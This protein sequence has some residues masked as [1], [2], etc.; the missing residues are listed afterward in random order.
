MPKLDH[1]LPVSV[2]LGTWAGYCWLIGPYG[3]LDGFVISAA[4]VVCIR[5]LVSLLG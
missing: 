4:A 2:T 3:P 1:W 5:A